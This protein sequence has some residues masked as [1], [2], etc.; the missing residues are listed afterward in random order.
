[1]PKEKYRLLIVDDCEDDRF[2]L[3][4]GLQ[5][6][7]GIEV[8]ASLEDGEYA[9]DYLRGQ[10]G[11]SD[12]SLFPL[13]DVLVVDIDMPRV[14]G[15]DVLQWLKEQNFSGLQVIAMS[16]SRSKEE[17]ARISALGAS[18]F[19]NKNEPIDTAQAIHGFLTASRLSDC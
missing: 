16:D 11:Y 6:L 1:M 14:S 17:L 10:N 15:F 2:L 18:H 19:I 3:E 9:I 5:K 12:R 13:P 8:V 7:S 4:R